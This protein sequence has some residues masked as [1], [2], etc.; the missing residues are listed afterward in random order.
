M[1]NQFVPDQK[2]IILKCDLAGEYPIYIYWSEESNKLLYSKSIEDLLKNSLIK[3]PLRINLRGLSF[4]LQSSVIPTPSTV[5]KDIYIL[6]MG[7]SAEISTYSK[8]IK[9]KFNHKFPFL[10]TDRLKVDCIEPNE[11]LILEKIANAT[12]NKVDKSKPTFLFHSAGKDSNTIALSLAAAGWQDRVTLITHKSKGGSDETEISSKIAKKLGFKHKILYQTE[13][14]ETWHKELLKNY[15]VN[16]NFPCVDNVSLAY[17]LYI[18]QLPELKNSN[19]IDGGGN[20]SYMMYLPKAYKLKFLALSRWTNYLNFIRN[21]LKSESILIPLLRTPA[22][23]C[24][25]TGL[26]LYDT[27]KIYPNVFDVYPYWKKRSDLNKNLDLLDFN[28]SIQ[29]TLR[30]SEISLRKAR[31]FA[32]SIKSN[33][34]LPFTNQ[35]VAE[36]FFK[37]PEKYLFDR[38]TLKNKLILRNI[39][40]QRIGLDSDKVG[41]KTFNHDT[42]LIV[43]LNWNEIAGEISR[44][45]LWNKEEVNILINRL[46]KT[47]K[48]SKKYSNFSG[49][50]IYRLYLISSWKNYSKYLDNLN[51]EN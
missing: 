48:T 35:N 34:I 10:N 46:R 1:V 33:L 19:I 27:K 4:L 12:I 6:N 9:V 8:K 31:I 29:T 49:V 14:F 36:Y 26:S 51:I 41:K 5:Y 16:S 32:D 11:N 22:E 20:D 15:F 28:N 37:I 18:H 2:K 3:K 39:L 7:D 40:K 21:Y 30:F 13:K 50:L 42:N 44:C 25:I 23:W 24:G 43:D 47:M 45:N 17:P 38:K